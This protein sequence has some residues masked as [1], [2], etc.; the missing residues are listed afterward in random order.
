M[1]GRGVEAGAAQARTVLHGDG[2][3]SKKTATDAAGVK[4]RAGG[5]RPEDD[6]QHSVEV[7]PQA[8]QRSGALWRLRRRRVPEG[9]VWGGRAGGRAMLTHRAAQAGLLR[10]ACADPGRGCPLASTMGGLRGG[11]TRVECGGEHKRSLGQRC[12][13][14]DTC[15]ELFAARLSHSPGCRRPPAAPRC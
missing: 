9:A 11:G 8:L 4:R 10:W 7:G 15:G 1:D 5:H 14:A 2:C 12:L 6:F 13:P 3:R